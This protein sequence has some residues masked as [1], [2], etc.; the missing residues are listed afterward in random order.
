VVPALKREPRSDFS[1]LATNQQWRRYR[2]EKIGR[3]VMLHNLS[4]MIVGLCVFAL[5]AILAPHDFA[6]PVDDDGDI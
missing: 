6:V 2:E 4:I 3:T 1:A 5:L